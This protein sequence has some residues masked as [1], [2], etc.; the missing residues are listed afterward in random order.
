MAWSINDIFSPGLAC[1]QWWV[2]IMTLPYATHLLTNLGG[3]VRSRRIWQLLAR[4]LHL[5]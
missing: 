2:L 4:L 3:K 1:S 5:D